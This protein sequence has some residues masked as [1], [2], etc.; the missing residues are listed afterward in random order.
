MLLALHFHHTQQRSPTPK[1]SYLVDS[2][3]REHFEVVTHYPL[4]LFRSN[5]IA[6]NA[7]NAKLELLALIILQSPQDFCL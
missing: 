7:A 6:E 3:T 4:P 1:K 2:F 5:L